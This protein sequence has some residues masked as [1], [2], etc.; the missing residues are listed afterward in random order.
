MTTP[1]NYK[2]YARAVND[3]LAERG[4]RHRVTPVIVAQVLITGMN[5]AREELDQTPEPTPRP[6]VDPVV[7]GSNTGATASVSMPPVSSHGRGKTEA[8]SG[9]VRSL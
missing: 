2:T 3:A 5:I 4:Y 1:V 6:V 9:V 8:P 7:E